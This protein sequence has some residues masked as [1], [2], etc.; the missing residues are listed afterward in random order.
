MK[1]SKKNKKFTFSITITGRCNASCEYCHF[2]RLRKRK[3][4]AIDMEDSLYYL[5][6]KFI[7]YC[8]QNISSDISFRFSGGDPMVLGDNLFTLANVGHSQTGI[9]PYVLTAGKELSSG[10]VDKA[11]ESSID[12]VFVSIENPLFPMK[13]APD[14][15][16]TASLIKKLTSDKLPIVP[17]VCVVPNHCFKHLFEICSWFYDKFGRIPV[18]SEINYGAYNKPTDTEFVDLGRSVEK[19]LAHF[20]S[21]TQLNLFATVVP[22]LAYGGVTPCIFELGLD[23]SHGIS[24]DNFKEKSVELLSIAE[25]VYYPNVNC[26]QFDCP[27]FDSCKSVKRNWMYT[28]GKLCQQKL[29]DYCKFKRILND[30][31]YRAFIDSS[32]TNTNCSIC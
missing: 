15:I 26:S 7:K 2:F 28:N 30:A 1:N 18:M 29:L 6:L 21:K 5:Y 25:D 11:K 13:G 22:E 9:K 17:G 12:H 4:V 24:V 8:K 14:P 32:H 20:A 10:W 16:K 23:N 3:E 31:Y 27:W 19:V